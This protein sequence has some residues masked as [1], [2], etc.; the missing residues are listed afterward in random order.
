ML[1]LLVYVSKYTDVPARTYGVLLVSVLIAILHASVLPFKNSSDNLL[2]T[3][4]LTILI[5]AA[6]T[7]AVFPGGGMRR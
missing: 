5:Y 7:K 6:G 1:T 3:L 2:E 4:S